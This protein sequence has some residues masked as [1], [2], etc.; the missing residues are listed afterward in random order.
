MIGGI[1]GAGIGYYNPY[2][3][4]YQRPAYP[5]GQAVQK[6]AFAMV[7]NTRPAA[8]PEIPDRKSVV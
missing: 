6:P 5:D 1:S 4:G 7:R 3:L 2:T 8:S